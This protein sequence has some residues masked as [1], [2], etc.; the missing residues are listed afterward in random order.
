MFRYFSIYANLTR[1]LYI[2]CVH[3]YSS[4]YRIGLLR[5]SDK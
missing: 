3:V 1:S 4:Y 5:A 2:R